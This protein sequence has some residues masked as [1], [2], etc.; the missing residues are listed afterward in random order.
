V[1]SFA[2]AIGMQLSELMPLHAD[3]SVGGHE[4]VSEARD[5]VDVVPVHV[6]A[7]GGRM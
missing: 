6:V 1:L 5:E 7:N 4:H 3:L 2:F